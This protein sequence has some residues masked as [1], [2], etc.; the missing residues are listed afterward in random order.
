MTERPAANGALVETTGPMDVD[1]SVPESDRLEAHL[2]RLM[3]QCDSIPLLD[4]VV[5]EFDTPCAVAAIARAALR[6][7]LDGKPEAI[8]E[9]LGQECS[10]LEDARAR[11]L[12]LDL[13]YAWLNPHLRLVVDWRGDQWMREPTNPEWVKWRPSE[14]TPAHWYTPAHLER[15]V[16]AY[17]TSEA[18]AGI[19]VRE[20]VTQFHGLSGSAKG[21]AVLADTGLDRT[22][23]A[24]LANGR[25]DSDAIGRLLHS[26][27]AHSRPVKPA[28][29]GVIG[30]EHLAA[31]MRQLGV[32]MDSFNY[33]KILG[34]T[35]ALPW[36]AEVAFGWRPDLGYRRLVTGVNWSPGINNPFRTMGKYGQ[37][38]DT[39][40]QR[41][42]IDDDCVMV[43]H[44]A[45][46]RVAYTDRGKSAVVIS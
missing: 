21:R 41:Q 16:V 11:F 40:L 5:D 24:D 2:R 3:A 12:Q 18:H 37:S 22:K 27:Q 7:H 35:D 19:S 6:W 25:L 31:R 9:R 10:I 44:L 15:L 1:V 38:L 30:E 26:M 45:C 42:R 14:P 32:Q 8:A 46:P 28:R 4:E 36:V 29:L 20:F 17:V 34:E 43:V 23:L 33:K 39:L 13:D